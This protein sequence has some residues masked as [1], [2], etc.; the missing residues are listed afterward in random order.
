MFAMF[1]L[2]GDGLGT[3]VT[4]VFAL[5]FELSAALQPAQKTARAS[6]VNKD[7]VRFMKF[8]PVNQVKPSVCCL[9]ANGKSSPTRGPGPSVLYAPAGSR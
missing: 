1:E 6:K 3:V 5:L 8:L 2:V 4:A 7:I 9:R